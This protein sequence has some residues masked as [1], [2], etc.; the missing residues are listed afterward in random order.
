VLNLFDNWINN[1]LLFGV[2]MLLVIIALLK[3]LGFAK[4][5]II[6]VTGDLIWN[7]LEKV[8][9][10]KNNNNNNNNNKKNPTKNNKLANL[11]IPI[12]GDPIDNSIS[13]VINI[14]KQ[15]KISKPKLSKTIRV[16]RIVL[17]KTVKKLKL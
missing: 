5:S 14:Q 7:L 3:H 11:T 1:A 2:A 8:E 10:N 4:L 9:K 15:I 12:G 13:T 17:K 16:N 6:R